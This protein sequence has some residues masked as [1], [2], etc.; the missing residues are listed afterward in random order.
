MTSIAHIQSQIGTTADG[1]WGDKSKDALKVALKNGTPIGITKNI[2]LNELLHSNTAKARGIDNTPDQYVLQNLIDSCV[3]LWQPVRDILGVP[4]HITSGYRSPKL[5]TAV[6]GSK[7]SAHMHGL[8]ID[9]RAPNFG[10]PKK[11][12]PYLEREL[13]RRGIGFDQAI[14]EY[15][16][17]PGS[18]VHLGYKHPGGAQRGQTFTIS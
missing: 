5:N 12:V 17:S 6:K 7:N 16:Q 15:P 2:S 14:I 3:K 18:W 8:A 11:I 10:T 4:M 1:I 13:A 9:F